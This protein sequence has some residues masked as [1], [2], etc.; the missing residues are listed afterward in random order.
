MGI[1]F[2]ESTTLGVRFLYTQRRILERSSS[3]L[4]S[5]WGRMNV[6]KV[7]QPDGS[8]RLLPEFEECR[9]IAKERGVPLRDVYSWITAQ[10]EVPK[11]S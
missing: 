3:E 8:F 11:V 6:K 9:R 4:D 1:L 2:S 5:P 7:V 10:G